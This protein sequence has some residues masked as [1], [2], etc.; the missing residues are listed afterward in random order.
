ML[1]L[2]QI[3]VILCVY[4][5][6]KYLRQTINSVL[7][8]TFTN[9]EFIIRNDSSTDKTEEIIKS[10]NDDRIIYVLHERQNIGEARNGACALA[11]GKYIAVIDDDDVALPTRLQEEYDYLENNPDYSV[12]GSSFY[13]I[14]VHDNLLGRSF[15]FTHD[16][17]LR[18]MA[19]KAMNGIANPSIMFRKDSYMR[20]QG[21]P[22]TRGWEDIILW[23]KLARQGKFKNLKAPLIYHRIIDDSLSNGIDESS[24]YCQISKALRLKM[25]QEEEYSDTDVILFNEIY[26]C[27]PKRK[28][29]FSWTE[30]IRKSKIIKVYKLLSK[31]IGEKKVTSLFIAI[32]DLYGFYKIK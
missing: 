19:K 14:D 32:H 25:C 23:S 21:F 26:S 22:S 3:S 6:E 15:L 20:T 24:I 13:F 30:T 10:Y 8:Q 29:N 7:S 1:G 17:T 9:F 12:V 28:N 11:R 16:K 2:P 5:G 18:K 31:I 4:N 27:I